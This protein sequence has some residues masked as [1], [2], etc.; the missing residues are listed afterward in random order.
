MPT[1]ERLIIPPLAAVWLAPPTAPTSDVGVGGTIRRLAKSTQLR[2]ITKARANKRETNH[3]LVAPVCPAILSR[4]SFRAKADV[5]FPAPSPE[6][7]ASRLILCGT[8][9]HIP[10]PTTDCIPPRATPQSVVCQTGTGDPS[11]VPGGLWLSAI[12]YWRSLFEITST[13]MLNFWFDW[14]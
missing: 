3:L 1:L 5:D 11:G 2:L 14:V 7:R 8:I 6:P 9:R 13:Q 4:R 10:A 12:S